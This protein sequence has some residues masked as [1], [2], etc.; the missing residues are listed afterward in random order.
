MSIKKSKLTATPAM[1][2]IEIQASDLPLC[3]PRPE[4]P[5]WNLHPRVYLPI[6]KSGEEECPYCS[7][8][9]VL[10]GAKV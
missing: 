2:P 8:R 6:E 1:I 10:V 3:C 5:L 4:V 9:Y 7:A